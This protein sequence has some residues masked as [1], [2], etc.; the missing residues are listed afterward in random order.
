MYTVIYVTQSPTPHEYDVVVAY[1]AQRVRRGEMTPGTAAR[2]QRVFAAFHRFTTASGRNN[3]REVDTHV[4]QAFVTA[5][6]RGGQPPATSTSRFRLTVVRDAYVALSLAGVA[7]SDPTSGLRVAQ[8]PQNHHTV[9]LTP[10]EAHRLRSAGRISPR[11]HLRPALVELALA[12]AS[13]FEAAATVIV[14]VNL[15]RGSVHLAGRRSNLDS[16]AITTLSARIA[17][18]R[19]TARRLHRS[20]DPETVAVALTRPLHSY[21]LTSI[22][23]GISSSLSRAMAAAGLAR[24]GL[25]AASV[26]EYAANRVYAV[27]GSVEAVAQVLGL[28]SLDAALGFIDRGWQEKYGPE[29]GSR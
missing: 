3:L 25:R 10:L 8:T 18:C 27:T 26:R 13:H 4:C 20:W 14:D 6:R 5:A 29:V 9:P 1:W 21:P 22:A 28:P 24:P 19:R 2:Y 16:F 23:P 15:D 7:T 17:A 11:D 12:G